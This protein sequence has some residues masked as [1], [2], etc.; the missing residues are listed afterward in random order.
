MLCLLTESN[1]SSMVD[2]QVLAVLL[3]FICLQ[4]TDLVVLV[5]LQTSI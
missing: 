1:G 5:G 4:V 2:E 3:G